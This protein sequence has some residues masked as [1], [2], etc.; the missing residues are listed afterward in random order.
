VG[1][2]GWGLG[3]DVAVFGERHVLWHTGAD[4]G[5][6]IFAYVIPEAGEGAVVFTGSA[7]GYRAILPLFEAMGVEPRFLARLRARRRRASFPVQVHGLMVCAVNRRDFVLAAAALA[8]TGAPAAAQ[9]FR[10]TRFSVQVHGRGPDVILIPGLTSG[11]DVWYATVRAVPGYRYHLVQVAGFAGEPARGNAQGPILE[12]LAEEIAR[13]IA[14]EGLRR[15]AIVGHSMGGTLALMVAARHPALVGKAMVVDMLPQPAGLFGGSADGVSPLAR[16]LGAMFS[17]PG[18]R[19]LLANIMGAFSPPGRDRRSDPDVV[20]RAMHE[21]AAIDLTPQMSRISAP[22]TIVYA[23]PDDP[24][25]RATIDRQF[26]SAYA[27]TRN[28]RLIRIDGSG[29]MVMADQPARFQAALR[30]FLRG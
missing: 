23:A 11:R 8:L 6:F 20:A 18:G 21:L 30:A 19:R 25:A 17:S 28:K 15:P 24:R 5:E 7:V 26:A 14:A 12:P 16:E 2:A 13:Y 29:H 22:L 1:V 27:G 4:R 9:R 3:R 10:P